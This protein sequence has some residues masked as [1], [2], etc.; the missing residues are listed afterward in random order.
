HLADGVSSPFGKLSP[1]RR[2]TFERLDS[3]DGVVLLTEAQRQDVEAA[4]GEL[5]NLYVCPNSREAV[6][7]PAGID[8]DDRPKRR[9][10]AMGALVPGKRFSHVI[11]A[12][13]SAR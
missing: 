7:L 6:D 2:H 8:L 9:G 12:V 1:G 11:R 5:G 13:R 4:F 3:F 10:V